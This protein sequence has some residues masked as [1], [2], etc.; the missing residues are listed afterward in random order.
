[1]IQVGNYIYKRV[2]T[3]RK[4]AVS[5]RSLDKFTWAYI[6]AAL[7]ST[8]DY[9][10]ESG[11]D[12][13]DENYDANDIAPETLAEMAADCKRFQEENEGAL[14]SAEVSGRYSVDEMAG[15]DFWMTRNGHGVGFWDGDWSE[16]EG[17]QLDEASSVF[18]EYDLYVGDDG[19]IYGS[20][21]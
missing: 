15:Y 3:S 7:S 17:D 2:D 12:P 11:G 6:D 16:P 1:M 5:L 10:D 21:G 8:S 13:L 19:M 14:D 18:G 20:G 9:S 4:G